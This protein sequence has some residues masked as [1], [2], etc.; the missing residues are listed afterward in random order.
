MLGA[1]IVVHQLL[2][3]R[4]AEAPQY[5]AG[6]R[7]PASE[8]LDAGEPEALA[9]ADDEFEAK[10]DRR[11]NDAAGGVSLDRGQV[12]QQTFVDSSAGRA[13]IRVATDNPTIVR[14][15]IERLLEQNRIAY[16]Q[17]SETP[18]ESQMAGAGLR[19]YDAVALADAGERQGL[20][21]S[22]KEPAGVIE[23]KRTGAK[24][25]SA[26]APSVAMSPAQTANPPVTQAVTGGGERRGALNQLVLV[27]RNVS[28]VEVARIEQALRDR[29]IGQRLTYQVADAGKS[30]IAPPLPVAGAISRNDALATTL[31]S[32]QPSATR[33]GPSGGG[34]EAPTGVQAGRQPAARQP[35]RVEQTMDLLI[36]VEGQAR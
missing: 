16:S 12:R 9:R 31:P 10:L 21:R 28:S 13:I 35:Q 6:L 20:T 5:S 7:S 14:A 34:A 18:A 33:T 30:E 2:P 27:A 8:A 26:A 29:Q 23:D 17:Q 15:E 22:D 25:A 36:I 32:L 11:K 3:Q 4:G 24:S 19:S 1:G